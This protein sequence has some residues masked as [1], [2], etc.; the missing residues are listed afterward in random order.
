[1]KTLGVVLSLTLLLGSGAA[2]ASGPKTSSFAP[3][4]P[5]PHSTLADKHGTH[6][7]SHKATHRKP[8]SASKRGTQ[9][10]TNPR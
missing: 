5:E 10:R 6:S 4:G 7:S 9:H 3:R 8:G 1:M 2:I